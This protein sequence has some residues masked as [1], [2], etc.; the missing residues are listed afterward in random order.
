MTNIPD[1]SRFENAY[2]GN[3]PWD[4]GRPQKAVVEVANKIKGTILDVGCGTGENALFFAS[5][6]HSVL[7]PR[8]NLFMMY[9]SD[10]E[11]GIQGPPQISKQEIE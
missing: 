4:F 2:A 6:G 10:E 3:A 5:R 9:F 8:G 7:K 1:R 11:P